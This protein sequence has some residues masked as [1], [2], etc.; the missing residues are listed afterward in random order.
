MKQMKKSLDEANVKIHDYDNVARREKLQKK[1]IDNLRKNVVNSE[2]R[3]AN[4]E[5]LIEKKEDILA[6]LQAKVNVTTPNAIHDARN[7]L[8]REGEDTLNAELN[9]SIGLN[10]ANAS[11]I[12]DTPKSLSSSNPFVFSP[13]PKSPANNVDKNETKKSVE[14]KK[15]VNINSKNNKSNDISKRASQLQNNVYNTPITVNKNAEDE[16]ITPLSE[17][18]IRRVSNLMDHPTRSI[19]DENNSSSMIS[20]QISQLRRRDETRFNQQIQSL[21]SAL[22]IEQEKCKELTSQLGVLKEMNEQYVEQLSVFENMSNECNDM[23]AKCLN[24]ENELNAKATTNTEMSKDIKAKQKEIESQLNSIN[25]LNMQLNKLKTSNQLELEKIK[26]EA[27]EAIESLKA[28]HL[29]YVSTIKTQ[30]SNEI[31][32]TQVN[33][34]DIVKN[35]RDELKTIREHSN[36][37]NN[38]TEGLLLKINKKNIEIEDLNNTN[39]EMNK[40]HVQEMERVR[41]KCKDEV[42][43]ATNHHRAS[44]KLLQEKMRDEHAKEILELNATLKTKDTIIMEQQQ[45][46]MNEAKALQKLRDEHLNQSKT[47]RSDYDEK[48]NHLNGMLHQTEKTFNDLTAQM[49]NERETVL[50]DKADVVQKHQKEIHLLSEQHHVDIEFLRKSQRDELS[51]LREKFNSELQQVHDKQHATIIK[52][53]RDLHND[54]N[55]TVKEKLEDQQGQFYLEKQSLEDNHKKALNG[56]KTQ[57]NDEIIATRNTLIAKQESYINA[58]KIKHSDEMRIQVSSHEQITLKLKQQKEHFQQE[59]SRLSENHELE[60]GL[61]IKD[62]KEA[63][64]RHTNE[65]NILKEQHEKQIHSISKT[66]NDTMQMLHVEFQ[67]QQQN[68]LN[69][70]SQEYNKLMNQNEE[71]I[72]K[73]LHAMEELKVKHHEKITMLKAKHHEQT[74]AMETKYLGQ[75]E[76]LKNVHDSDHSTL[77]DEL[78]QDITNHLSTIKTLKDN[79]DTLNRNF[80]LEKSTLEEQQV[81]A[82]GELTNKYNNDMNVQKQ[83][84]AHDIEILQQTIDQLTSNVKNLKSDIVHLSDKHVLEIASLNEMNKKNT[85]LLKEQ[86]DNDVAYLKSKSKEKAMKIYKDS[87]QKLKSKHDEYTKSQ[88]ERYTT[89]LN[90]MKDNKLKHEEEVQSLQTLLISLKNKHFDELKQLNHNNDVATKSLMEKHSK[91]MGI[92]TTNL[93]NKCDELALKLNTEHRNELNMLKRKHEENINELKSKQK[94]VM[95][96]NTAKLNDEISK[97]SNKLQNYKD[98]S[99][100]KLDDV[101]EDKEQLEEQ[102]GE[103]QD[104]YDTLMDKHDTTVDEYK[105][106][107][108]MTKEKYKA[109]LKELDAHTRSDLA[110]QKQEFDIQLKKA[111]E[112][113]NHTHSDE[114]EKLNHAIQNSEREIQLLNEE[115]ESMLKKHNSDTADFK[116]AIESKVSEMEQ[117]KVHH[118]DELEKM[119]DT[120]RASQ[121]LMNALKQDAEGANEKNLDEIKKLTDTLALQEKEIALLK[122]NTI[123]NQATRD[124]ELE[125]CRELLKE[126]EAAIQRLK[127]DNTDLNGALDMKTKQL[128]AYKTL[129]EKTNKSFTICK[130]NWNSEKDVLSKSLADETKLNAHLYEAVDKLKVQYEEQMRNDRKKLLESISEKDNDIKTATEKISIAEKHVNEKN[131]VI[132]SLQAQLHEAKETVQKNN[133]RFE[134]K[135]GELKDKDLAIVALENVL[136]ESKEK[137][138]KERGALKDLLMEEQRINSDMRLMYE[139]NNSTSDLQFGTASEGEDQVNDITII[140]DSSWSDD[141]D[142]Y[143]D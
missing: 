86:H 139:D 83:K 52:M 88:N 124:D 129:S 108:R 4:L 74:V 92:L 111:V 24:L 1:E 32:L 77:R 20:T 47:L 8:M 140:E 112:A 65:V 89:L 42:N 136:N 72:T 76:K 64:V 126:H 128:S 84:S 80:S 114:V 14:T 110:K 127:A 82:I 45:E 59:V 122:E 51:S 97:L 143:S 39:I 9:G 16:R 26:L 10:D 36:S 50:K 101:I 11:S 70:H 54:L 33:N 37:T 75:I 34:Q 49:E 43:Q 96:S 40:K 81:I 94:S 134:V 53:K 67:E 15:I 90:Q 133:D 56:L 60:L 58:L 121:N 79:V 17:K 103:L 44:L 29:E 85:I 95:Q 131:D 106:T 25:Q 138:K 116:H 104:K 27:S 55:S 102:L 109:L 22:S 113:V 12:T 28:S 38:N 100:D 107:L 87:V 69:Q 93:N 13:F 3:N 62:R 115:A 117:M 46:I 98:D 99:N 19:I 48:I 118:S 31:E 6:E 132:A 141:D 63:Y 73:H 78:E 137:W 21:T 123:Q 142:D 71:L 41:N 57:Y 120:I 23:K 68:D 135:L 2:L 61:A 7:Q 105:D 125:S 35:L 91:S 18:V 66:H 130:T 5:R 30:H 119:N